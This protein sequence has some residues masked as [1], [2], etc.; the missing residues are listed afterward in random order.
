MYASCD[1][2]PYTVGRAKITDTQTD[3]LK[4]RL[5]DRVKA[6]EPD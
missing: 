1:M 4:D 2:L 6:Y 5:N 3:I